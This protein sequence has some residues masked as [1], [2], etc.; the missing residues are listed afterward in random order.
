M[1]VYRVATIV[2]PL[3]FQV[4]AVI[5]LPAPLGVGDNPWR[6]LWFYLGGLVRNE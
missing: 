3:A 1:V 2:P 5:S 4:V 6:Q